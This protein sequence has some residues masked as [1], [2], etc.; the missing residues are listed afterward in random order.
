MTASF[1]FSRGRGTLGG[2]PGFGDGRLVG[3]A[4]TASL[5]YLPPLLSSM[6]IGDGSGDGVSS[7]TILD[8]GCAGAGAGGVISGTILAAAAGGGGGGVISGTSLDVGGTGA[9]TTGAGV[10]GKN[11]L[12]LLL[13]LFW[14]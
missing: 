1:H 11:S 7:R 2:G 13:L 4:E 5:M 3:V 14:R 8:G 10:G 6:S 12:L 9:G